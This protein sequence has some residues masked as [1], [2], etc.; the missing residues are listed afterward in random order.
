M[1]V[2]VFGAGAI[3]SH[4]AARLA[5]TN[6]ADTSVV[7]RGPQL[8]AIRGHGLL[9]K[10]GGDEIR[11]KPK[12]ATDD[13]STLPQQDLLLVTLKA[14]VLPPLAATLERLL[15]PRGTAVF[16]L[17]GIPWWWRHGTAGKQG[18]LP[19]LD[20]EGALW[21]RLRE[22]TLGCVVSSPNEL[23]A[24]AVVLHKGGNR[25][26]MGEP[27][28]KTTERMR[29]VVDLFV[30]SGLPAEISSDLRAE[31]WRKLMGN[32]STNPLAALTRLGIS[33]IGAD[34]GLRE[35]SIALKNETL[36]VAAAMGW[37]LRQELDVEKHA[38]RPQAPGGPRPSMLQDV[39]LGRRLEVEAHLGQMQ[40]F[41]REAGVPVPTVDVVLPLL[42]GLD[43][44]LARA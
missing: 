14:H 43:R 10:S 32:A 40:A 21:T 3:G 6:V 31:V 34:E 8:E 19:L 42:R 29:V 5:A 4:I 33:D 18:P 13:P 39:L 27:D 37:D 12:T 15:A 25:F 11:G 23:E 16:F 22:R 30:R 26:A 20:P 36:A 28:G 1:K 35:I 24:P 38:R 9:L 44:S 17:N 41:A 7:A 2:C